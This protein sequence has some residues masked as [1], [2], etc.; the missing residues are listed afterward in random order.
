[1]TVQ[2]EVTEHDVS[3]F[4]IYLFDHSP[5]IK[6]QFK[7]FNCIS[8]IIVSITLFIFMF[9]YFYRISSNAFIIALLTSLMAGVTG[10]LFSIPIGRRDYVRKFKQIAFDGKKSK[11]EQTTVVLNEDSIHIQVES[12]ESFIKWSAIT[13]VKE[14]DTHIFLLLSSTTAF[15]VPKRAFSTNETMQVFYARAEELQRSA[16]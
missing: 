4:A 5:V 2:Y 15:I 16:Q 11:R 1:M 6:K 14:T 9:A 3:A 12:G 10:F 7:N 8:A 13:D